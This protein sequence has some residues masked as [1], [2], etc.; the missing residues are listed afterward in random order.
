MNRLFLISTIILTT[1]LTAFGQDT[2]ISLAYS[3]SP[4]SYFED[5][6]TAN[7]FYFDTTQTN[8][9]WQIGTPSKTV[10]D[11]A[12]STPLALLTD[13]LNTYP[14]SNQSSFEFV[15]YTDDMTDIAFW[16]RFDTDSLKDGGIIEV[17]TDGGSTWTNIVNDT[18]NGFFL[19]NFY[20][21]TDTINS[22]NNEPGFTGT[23][24][25]WVKSR[26]MKQGYM[27]FFRFRFTFSS[28][29][30]DNGR[31][32]WMIDNFEFICLGTGIEETELNS[33]I[34]LYPNPT[35]NQLTIETENDL[36]LETIKV[37]D[38]SGRLIHQESKKLIET[39]DWTSGLYFIEIITDQG[40]LKKKI[41]K[42]NVR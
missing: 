26:I 9:I 32:G 15:I 1:T 10:F 38:N 6:D 4:V 34:N 40:T 12:N 33:K 13:T 20:T 16:H 8:N 27:N 29:T 42:I 2:I 30:I 24:G 36:R 22:F 3:L 18:V 35:Y 11:S 5:R 14:D 31:D 7:Y 28:D 19:D 17:S 39:I 21:S 37:F 25:G 41:M 23:S